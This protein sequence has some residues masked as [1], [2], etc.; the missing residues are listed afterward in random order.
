MYILASRSR[1]LYTGVTGELKHRVMQHKLGV[2][3][4]FTRKYRIH[5]LVYFEIYSDVRDA[6]AREKQIK[7]WRREKKVKLIEGQN[8][9]WDD[10]AAGWFDEKQVP[11]LR[12]G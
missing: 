6:I 8:P 3:E 5:R 7:R 11:R 4:G 10:L 2:I 9:T 1:N 12:S